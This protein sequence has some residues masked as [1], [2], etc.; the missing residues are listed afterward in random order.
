MNCLKLQTEKFRSVFVCKGC[1]EVFLKAYNANKYKIKSFLQ[2]KQKLSFNL[3]FFFS[4]TVDVETVGKI[5]LIAINRPEKKNAIDTATAH[6][7]YRA[8]QDFESNDR[9]RAAVLYG[10]GIY[11]LTPSLKTTTF[12]LLFLNNILL[13]I[14]Y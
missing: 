10:K 4:E 3:F 6:Q 14:F 5:C 1:F 2:A 9:I 13:L 11:I 12:L 7:L 8:F